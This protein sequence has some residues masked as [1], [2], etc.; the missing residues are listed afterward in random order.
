[1]FLRGR[2]P[3]YKPDAL[4]LP[5][6]THVVKTPWLT[7]WWRVLAGIA[8]AILLVLIIYGYVS[9]Y[10][11]AAEESIRM[12]RSEQAISRAVARRLRELPGGRR[13]FYRNASVGFD[14]S[15]TNVMNRKVAVV[16]LTARRGETGISVSGSL[17]RKDART[18]QWTVVNP[19]ELRD[20][21]RRGQIYRLGDFYFRIG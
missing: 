3:H 17:E 12:A 15:G 14:S 4:R 6:I 20:A 2:D 19:E 11:F 18:R 10:D 16:M 9:P 21:V 1:V 13:G 7:C 5:V 8:G